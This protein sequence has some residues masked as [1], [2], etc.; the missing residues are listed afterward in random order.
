MWL[1][2]VVFFGIEALSAA[3][4]SVALLNVSEIACFVEEDSFLA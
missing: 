3:R 4:T 2:F 1:F